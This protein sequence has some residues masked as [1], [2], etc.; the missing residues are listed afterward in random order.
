MDVKIQQCIFATNAFADAFPDE[1]IS[2]WEQ[3]EKEVPESKRSGYH[4]ADNRA[5]INWLV[6]RK[7]PVFVQFAQGH[8]QMKVVDQLS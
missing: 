4:G 2:L 6:L 7:E 3:F 5:Y 1:H 8:I